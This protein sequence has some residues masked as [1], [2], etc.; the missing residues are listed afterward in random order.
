MTLRDLGMHRL[1]DL[2]RP[3]HIYQAQAPDLP[4]DFPPLRTLDARPG[5]LPIQPTPLIGREQEMAAVTALLAR[6]DVRLVTLTGPGGTG[7]TRLGLQSAA[8]LLD[9]S[10]RRR[11]SSISRQSAIRSWSSRRSPRRSA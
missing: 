2:S 7:K 3:E 4:A 9:R 10:R 1:K 8:E 6:A 5:N 11:S